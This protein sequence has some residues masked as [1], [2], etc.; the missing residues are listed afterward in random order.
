MLSGLTEAAFYGRRFLSFRPFRSHLHFLQDK[1]PNV[2]DI[3]R[4]IRQTTHSVGYQFSVAD[5]LVLGEFENRCH[6]IRS[7]TH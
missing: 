3:R 7:L 6:S 1:Q 4:E 5:F 2:P